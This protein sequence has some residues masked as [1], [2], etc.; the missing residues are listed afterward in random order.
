MRISDWSS[1]VCSSD[2]LHFTK[3]RHVEMTHTG[4]VKALQHMTVRIDFDGIKR[5][6]RELAEESA[7]IRAQLLGEQNLHRLIGAQ[8]G[9]G[10]IDRGEN[11]QIAC[12]REM[13]IAECV[14]GE[15]EKRGDRK[16]TRLNSSH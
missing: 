14:N 15:G 8:G 16:S 7:G 2:L 11:R 1:D 12:V 13:R 3:R 9:N 6:A 5:L 10:F 4:V